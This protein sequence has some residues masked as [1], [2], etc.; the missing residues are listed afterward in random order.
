[1]GVR[2]YW[3]SN[4]QYNGETTLV[5]RVEGGSW[6]ADLKMWKVLQRYVESGIIIEQL[7]ELPED[8][9]ENPCWKQEPQLWKL[10]QSDSD[11]SHWLIGDYEML[12]CSVSIPK[13]LSLTP[14][15]LL[16]IQRN[17]KNSCS[18]FVSEYPQQLEGP[19]SKTQKH[20]V[21]ETIKHTDHPKKGHLNNLVLPKHSAQPDPHKGSC[22]SEPCQGCTQRKE[23]TV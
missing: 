19:L 13:W 23:Q 14:E 16:D 9:V 22:T 8:F 18:S 21:T 5:E 4:R 20:S 7:E 10:I 3:K 15:F 11:A 6:F 2:F 1:M 12:E 17:L